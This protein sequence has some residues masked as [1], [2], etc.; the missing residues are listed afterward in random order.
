MNEDAT[1]AGNL[2]SINNGD[3]VE[4]IQKGEITDTTIDLDLGVTA[5]DFT[6]K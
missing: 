5:T 6:P 3:E 1:F 2:T 4:S